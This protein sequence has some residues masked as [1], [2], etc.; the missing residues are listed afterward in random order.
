MFSKRVA[1]ISLL[2]AM[3]IAPMGLSAGDI[4]E[5]VLSG[6]VKRAIEDEVRDNDPPRRRVIIR[7][8]S[9]NTTTTSQA[10]REINRETQTALNYFGFRAGTPDG[11]LGR[12]SRSAISQYQSHVGYPRTGYLDEYQRDF[13]MVSYYRAIAGDQTTPGLTPRDPYAARSLLLVYQAQDSGAVPVFQANGGNS[14]TG[15][16]TVS[17]LPTFMTDDGAQASLSSHCNQINLITNANSRFVTRAT[18][19]DPGLALNEQFCLARSYAIAQ[20]EKLASGVKGVSRS[21]L[22]AECATFGPTMQDYVTALSLSPRDLVLG[23]VS[24]FVQSTGMSPKQ[25]NGTARVCLSVGYRTDNLDVALGSALL[26][27]AL[28]EAAY[29]ELL[30]HHL[31]QGYGTSTRPDLALAWYQASFD[32]IMG[33]APAVFAPEDP[34]RAELIQEAAL[35]LGGVSQSAAQGQTGAGSVLPTFSVGSD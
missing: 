14:S 17:G 35:Q 19:T 12:K 26:L 9:T 23:D 1:A 28:G 15:F 27:T 30:G 7:R 29:G 34:E 18:M 22:E 11:V 6:I 25:L 21:Q 32:A 31:T 10:T 2:V 4:V 5:D 16:A 13:L 3:L 24:S 33:G 8:S 20:G